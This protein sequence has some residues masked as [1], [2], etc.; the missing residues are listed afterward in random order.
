MSGVVNAVSKKLATSPAPIRSAGY[1]A[2]RGLLWLLYY[3]PYS[4]MRKTA[5]AL[6]FAAGTNGGRAIYSRF[7]SGLSHAAFRMELISQGRTEEIDRLFRLP[8]REQFEACLSETGSALLVVPHCHGSLI[9]VRGLAARYPTLLLVREPKNDS[10]AKA[11][12]RFFAHMGCEVLDVRRNSETMV[13][14]AVLKALR[15]GKIVIGT[16]DRIKKAPA[17]DEPVSGDTVRVHMFGEPVGIAGWPARFA[18]KAGVPILP[19]M[20]EHT[21]ENV[22]LHLGEPVTAGD[23]RQTTQSW[24]SALE[25]FFCRFPGD[26]IFAYDKHWA[27]IL[28]SRAR[29]GK[30]GTTGLEDRNPVDGVLPST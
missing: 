28:A 8:E 29:G 5:D 25:A 22:T 18:A 17:A 15:E 10:R 7:V 20:T 1:G 2:L 4:H 30:P 16:V 21:A 11:E 13:A 23:I 6:A 27:R 19:V 12:R 14:R 9:A 26:W 24:A 3:C